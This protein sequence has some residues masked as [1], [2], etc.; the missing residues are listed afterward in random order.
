MGEKNLR[1]CIV[2]FRIPK[3]QADTAS[4]MLADKPVLGIRSTNQFFRKVGLDF[5]A[6]RLT[7]KNPEHASVDTSVVD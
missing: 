7:Y 5:L 2:S 6:G 1:E 3:S 4:K